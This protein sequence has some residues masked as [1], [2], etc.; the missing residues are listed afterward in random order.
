MSQL[1]HPNNYDGKTTPEQ[2]EALL[3]SIP[4][5]DGQGEMLA[6]LAARVGFYFNALTK[7]GIEPYIALQLSQAFQNTILRGS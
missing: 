7:Q 1:N 6:N 5:E 3:A 4:L 2:T